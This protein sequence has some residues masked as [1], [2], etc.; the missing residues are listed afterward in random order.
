M[1]H[2]AEEERTHRKELSSG[3]ELTVMM[4][5]LSQEEIGVCHGLS[6]SI[7]SQATSEDSTTWTGPLQPLALQPPKYVL[8]V[9]WPKVGGAVT[10]NFL[11]TSGQASVLAASSDLLTAEDL[12]KSSRLQCQSPMSNANLWSTCATARC[13]GSS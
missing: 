3:L 2:I 11:R 13:S 7:P 1:R 6:V 4:N 9:I 12:I 10:Q 8:H 5:D